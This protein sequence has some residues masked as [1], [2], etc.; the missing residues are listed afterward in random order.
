MEILSASRLRETENLAV[1]EY[2][3]TIPH[4]IEQAALAVY[5]VCAERIPRSAP[6]LILAGPGNNGSD[7]IMAAKLFRGGGY[8][9]TVFLLRAAVEKT[10]LTE[11]GVIVRE[12]SSEEDIDKDQ[13]TSVGL[14]IDAL[15]GIGA[16][17]PASGAMAALIAAANSSAAL[18][19]AVDIPTG[20]LADIPLISGEIFHADITVTFTRPK[21]SFHLAPAKA[22]C[23]EVIV[24]DVGIPQALINSPL[25]LLTE[26][27]TPPPPKRTPFG[28]K[29]LYG[30]AVIAGGSAGKSG[31][32]VL[33]S[34]A[35]LRAGAG[36]VTCALPK[37][38]QWALSAQPELMGF[39]GGT[40]EIFSKK[41]AKAL[42]NFLKP[43]MTLAVGPGL[44]REKETAAFVRKLIKGWDNPIVLDADGLY[45]LDGESLAALSGR[46]VLTPHMGEFFTLASRSFG[47][48]DKDELTLNR[49]KISY[50]YAVKHKLFLALKGAET[51]ISLPDGRQFISEWGTPALSKGGSGDILTGIITALI[52]QGI[53]IESALK[54]ACKTQGDAARAACAGRAEYSV[55]PIDIIN[56]IGVK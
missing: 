21:P 4:L 55:T 43:H 40:E 6:V 27:N 13:F 33:A 30:H 56:S 32:A 28:Y 8:P 47:E 42:L 14:I 2:G 9:V 22:L 41:D 29:N 1:R 7:G 48:M 31:A 5:E 17:R 20:L 16:N 50:E 18:K 51:I 15:L 44:G 54:T 36:L 38:L 19:V 11:L 26:E 39:F 52:T 24:K 10:A 34:L 37:A 46:G 35:A 49:L 3:R 53:D 23:G 25:T 12:I 45:A